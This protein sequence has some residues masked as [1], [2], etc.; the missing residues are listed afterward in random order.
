MFFLLTRRLGALI[1]KAS[2]NY[3]MVNDIVFEP[4]DKLKTFKV[5]ISLLHCVVC[6]LIG[7]SMYKFFI[8]P[9][10]IPHTWNNAVVAGACCLLFALL[11]ASSIK[12][13]CI[14]MIM[15]LEALGE[16][17]RSVIKALVITFLIIGPLNNILLNAKE[18]TRVIECTTHL[19]YK[20]SKTK[21]DLAVKPF[22]NAFLN[23]DRDLHE[24][25]RSFQKVQNLIAPVLEEIENDVHPQKYSTHLSVFYFTRF[26]TCFRNKEAG[27]FTSPWIY[28]SGYK[29]KL[30]KRCETIVDGGLNKCQEAFDETFKS[31]MNKAPRV[32][33][34]IICIPL[35]LDA[36]CSITNFFTKSVADVCDPSNVI[37]SSFGSEYVQLK[38]KGRKFMSHYGNVS[39]NYTTSNLKELRVV[40][41]ING[42]SQKIVRNLEDKT[43]FVEN[44]LK[45]VEKFMVFVYL[46]VIYGTLSLLFPQ[47]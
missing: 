46:K 27:N 5:I 33:N 41:L 14:W 6:A 2:E 37:D 24:V 40:N 10:G 21:F 47:V 26:W 22:T 17:S 19:T 31:C 9:F 38:E 34:S 39:I 11:T 20:L 45:V 36:I 4:R 23:M 29:Q 8:C 15:W 30:K 42:T 1:L 44:L 35:K 16:A 32:L 3:S 43:N 28:E 18:I 7:F 12:F 25:A 13:R